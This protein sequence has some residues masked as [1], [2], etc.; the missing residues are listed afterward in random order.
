MDE[1]GNVYI[2]S[3]AISRVAA[4]RNPRDISTPE[5]GDPSS[6]GRDSAVVSGGGDAENSVNWVGIDGFQDCWSKGTYSPSTADDIRK[7]KVK[8]S[9]YPSYPPK[10]PRVER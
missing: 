1:E 3:V 8:V 2:S 5:I 7:T 4:R 9:L 6:S 10:V